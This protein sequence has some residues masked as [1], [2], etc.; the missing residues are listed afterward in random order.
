MQLIQIFIPAYDPDGNRF[1]EKFFTEIKTKLTTQFGGV[2]IYQRA[3][4]TG[5][6][7][8][9]GKTTRD[10]IIIFEVMAE[11]VE[12]SFWKPYKA[13]LE[14]QFRQQQLLIRSSQIEIIN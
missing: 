8:E 4:A 1:D 13:A 3:P 2:T 11:E 5:L 12:S 10:E 14:A 9:D 6:W 7:K